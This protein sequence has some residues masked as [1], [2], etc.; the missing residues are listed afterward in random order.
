VS[1][2][3]DE[4]SDES[5]CRKLAWCCEHGRLFL[6]WSLC[7]GIETKVSD[8]ADKGKRFVFTK[9]NTKDH[10]RASV[11]PKGVGYGSDILENE[12]L[13]LFMAHDQM[14]DLSTA[15]VIPTNLSP[16][17][18]QMSMSSTKA[19]LI[20]PAKPADTAFAGQMARLP[21]AR[22]E[23]SAQSNDEY[24]CQL[25]FEALASLLRENGRK[26]TSAIVG[27]ATDVG[28]PGV[29]EGIIARGA[30]FAAAAELLRNDSVD[31]ISSLA[32]LYNALL[33]L[34]CVMLGSRSTAALV[35]CDRTVYPLDEQLLNFSFNTVQI[36]NVNSTN[37][38]RSEEK[39]LDKSASISKCL[40][41]VA[42]QCRDYLRLAPQLSSG[43]TESPDG[44]WKAR[45]TQRVIDV[46]NIIASGEAKRKLSVSETAVVGKPD[47]SSRSLGC[48]RVMELPDEV[49]LSRFRYQGDAVK[50]GHVALT[51]MKA[52]VSQVVDLRTC[53]PEHGIWVRHGASRCDI[54]KVVI[55]GPEGTPY[56]YGLYEFDLFCPAQFPK[57]PPKMHF[58]TTGGGRARFNPNLYENGKGR[59][60]PLPNI[61][62]T[63]D[64]SA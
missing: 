8:D 25:Y 57:V 15:D 40:A 10:K 5:T 23:P 45:I 63:S 56:Q 20:K 3:H 32:S 43:Y 17:P 47:E 39:Q 29:V 24:Y 14:P 27:M 55:M 51:R 58:C 12:P 18:L 6:I 35:I 2:Q 52:L 7:C 9:A 28:P 61:V 41:A 1:I 30:L 37:G 64:V 60:S 38:S 19:N 42:G 22:N 53:L 34:V 54:M 4:T 50:L 21:G 26:S 33:D 11:L 49:I 44:R 59:L 16:K 46:T 48:P 13:S 62:T 36:P 31:Y